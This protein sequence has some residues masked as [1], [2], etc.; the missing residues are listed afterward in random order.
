M[1]RT[2]VDVA[3]EHGVDAGVVAADA[4]LRRGLANPTDLKQAIDRCH[5]WPGSASAQR[6]VLL[7]DGRAESVLESVSRVRVSDAG[8]PLPQLQAKVGDE[9]GRFIARLD[10]YWPE[11]GVAGEADGNLKYD[12]G[13]NAIV[14]ER[15]RQQ[16]LEDLG[17][18]FVRWEWSDLGRFEVVARRIRTAFT[19]G[20]PRGH[21][22][23]WS[24][25]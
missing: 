4:A 9:T 21:G 12:A 8:L 16:R 2:I 3:R 13:R 14:A 23:R 15:R 5:R 18:V 11:Y 20:I 7:G 24:L 17:L 10:F 25:L 19:R 6:V 1:P 22:Q